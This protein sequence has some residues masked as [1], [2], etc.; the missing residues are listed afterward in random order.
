M[1]LWL[2]QTGQS[3]EQMEALDLDQ[4]ERIRGQPTEL[5]VPEGPP[6]LAGEE[7]QYFW[8]RGNKRR[9]LSPNRAD[10]TKVNIVDGARRW[11]AFCGMLPGKPAWKPLFK[12]GQR[13][14][15]RT[16]WPVSDA[17]GESRIRALRTVRLSLRQLSAVYRKC[18]GEH[19][20]S[21]LRDHFV[22]VTKLEYA[23][24]FGLRLEPEH[25][26]V[27]GPSGFTYLAHFR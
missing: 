9:P 21:R 22:A 16:I 3:R 1:G 20:K 11:I 17:K 14:S 25:K 27:L 15:C 19:L 18:T 23:R 10:N 7:L 8:D 4:I 12:L 5:E 6:P 26:K 13:G 2:A 24:L